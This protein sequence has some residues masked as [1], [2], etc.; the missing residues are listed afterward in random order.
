PIS[1]TFLPD[2]AKIRERFVE[3][4]DL[5]SPDVVDV[6]KITAESFLEPSINAMFVLKIRKASARDDR[7]LSLTTG[8][9]EVGISPSIGA[10]NLSSISLR[11]CTLL[12]SRNLI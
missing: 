2:I 6:T 7:S 4:K 9:S 3:T 11:E 12:S 1:K 10:L 5:P 8:S